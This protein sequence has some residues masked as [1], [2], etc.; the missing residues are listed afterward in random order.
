MAES[1]GRASDSDLAGLASVSLVC[2]DFDGVMTDN[3]VLVDQHGIESVVCNRADGLGC[4]LLRSAGVEVVIVST[5]SNRVVAARA[6]KLQIAVHHDCADKESTVRLMAE[7]RGLTLSDVVFVGNDVNDVAAMRAVGWPIAPADA[8]PE[9]LAIAR[10]V[11]S[12]A[13]GGGVVRELARLMLAAR[14]LSESSP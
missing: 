8:A 13:G 4:D 11:T 5:E 14:G 6:V 7:E 9:A 3:R 12:A 1:A 2:C 10:I